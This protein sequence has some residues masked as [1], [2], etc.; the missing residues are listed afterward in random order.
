LLEEYTNVLE[1]VSS[2][3]SHSAS[4]LRSIIGILNAI[5][6]YKEKES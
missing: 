3:L 6:H 2:V 1:L 5:Q 4:I